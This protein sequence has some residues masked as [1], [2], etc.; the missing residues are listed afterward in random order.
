MTTQ[1]G[2]AYQLIVDKYGKPLDNGLVYIGQAGQNAELYPIQVFYDE[3]FTIPAPQPLRTINGYFSRNGSPAKIFIQGVQCSIIVKDKFKILQ[4]LDLFYTG[5]LS[6]KGIT[7][8]DV[9]YGTITQE[10]FNDGFESIAD[11]LAIENPKDGMQVYVKGYYKPANFALA[12]PYRG[13]GYRTYIAS[14]SSENDGGLC[15]NG[16]VLQ[17]DGDLDIDCIGAVLGAD[18]SPYIEKALTYNKSIVIRGSYTLE[19]VVGIPVQ[20][21]YGSEVIVIRGENQATLTVNCP[22]A[23]FTS[24]TAKQNPNSTSNLF[25]AK[26]DVSG[27]NFIGTTVANSVVFN[28][29]RLYNINIHHNNF[30]SNITIVK[31]YIDRESGRSYTQSVSINHNHLANVYRVIDTDKAYNMDFS[32]NMC[33]ACTGGLYIGADAGWDPTSISLTIHRN[34]WEGSGLLLKTLGGLAACNIS[35]NYFESNVTNDALTL[36][37][38]IYI[39]RSGTGAGYSNG[40]VIEGNLFSGSTSISDYVDVR[41]I[42]Q[43]TESLVSSKNAQVIPPTFIGNWSNSYLLTNFDGA[44]LIGNRCNN[45]ATMRNA[46]SSQEGRVSFISG[47]L[48]KT[49][50]GTLAGN[51]LAFMNIDTRACLAN[52]YAQTNFKTTFDVTLYFRTSG[53][54]NTASCTFKLDVFVYT[55][56]GASQPSKANLKCVMYNFMQSNSSDV[57]VSGANM[58]DV[59]STPTLTLTNNGDGTYKLELGKFTNYSAP[60]WGN[61]TQ[62]KVEYTSSS[63]LIASVSPGYSTANLLAIS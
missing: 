5:V 27:I 38:L 43:S 23:V 6:G 62:Y 46:Y 33:E 28:G 57:I 54:V 20:N 39:D 3:D 14:R 26:I 53:A 15:I 25:T 49:L 42:N 60:N 29:D 52:A 55:P 61:I 47:Y 45:R 11:M 31:G 10:Q 44:I 41:I 34:L 35:A 18:A 4:W 63:T 13:G 12:Q 37:C 16:W 1:I 21:N 9:Q 51:N 24:A 59:I 36:K 30:K 56:F 32:Y 58:K 48:D 40:V 50:T 22:N 2:N 7:A 8:S 17:Y 19:T